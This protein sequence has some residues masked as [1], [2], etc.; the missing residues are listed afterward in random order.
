MA[1]DAV[2]R[3][4]G[5]RLAQRRETLAMSQDD[6]ARRAGIDAALIPAWEAGLSRIPAEALMR[7]AAALDIRAA[8]LM[9]RSAT[10]LQAGA[11]P[12]RGKPLRH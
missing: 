9:P 11:R 1:D 5:A 12:R 8:D 6:L 7:L 10:D 3:F 4:I 2:N